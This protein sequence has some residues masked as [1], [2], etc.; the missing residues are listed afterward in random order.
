MRR[1]SWFEIHDHPLFPTFLRDL[2]TDA[3]EAMWNAQDF[4][5]PAAARLQNAVDRSG[6]TRIVDLCS[7]GG[8]PWLSFSR[9]LAGEG[10]PPP[11]VLTDKYPNHNAFRKIESSSGKAICFCAEPIDATRIPPE[12]AG[13]R[14]M[15]S[16]FHHFSPAEAHA[17]LRDAF[18]QRQGIAIFEGAK[19]DWRTMAVVF[20]VPVLALRLAP[21]IRPF[22]WTRLFWTYCVP[23]IPFTLWFDGILSCLRSYS[24]DDMQ[25]LVEDLTDENYGWEIGEERRGLTTISYL[26]GFPKDSR[27]AR[28]RSLVEMQRPA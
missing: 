7:G 14:T 23:V 19:C 11:I 22:R 27:A 10:A 21:K 20:A 13:F 12:L 24:Q 16:T 9:H 28:K 1:K 26:V 2:V 4:Y 25:E 5:G 17:I 18:V 6:A 3:L 15:F 8:G